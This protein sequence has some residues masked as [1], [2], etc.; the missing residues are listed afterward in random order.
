M[1]RGYLGE[2]FD[3]LLRKYPMIKFLENPLYNEANNISS[4]VVAKDLLSNAYVIES[5]LL[6]SNPALL[7][8]YQ[9]HSNYLGI[10]SSA[11]TIGA[12]PRKKAW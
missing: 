2:Q 4:I 11:A 1:V 10:R 12:F 9:Y 5:D 6:L 7:T 8:K 3:Q